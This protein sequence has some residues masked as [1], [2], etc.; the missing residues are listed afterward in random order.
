MKPRHVAA[1]RNRR[2]LCFDLF[3]SFACFALWLF[4]RARART[5]NAPQRSMYFRALLLSRYVPLDLFDHQAKSIDTPII[6]DI[7]R[8]EISP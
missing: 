4:S 7:F 2:F 3:D 5:L 8:D 6:R 1:W